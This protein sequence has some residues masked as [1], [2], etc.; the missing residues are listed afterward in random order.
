MV[1]RRLVVSIAVIAG[2]FATTAASAAMGGV[3][4]DVPEDH[5]FAH[6]IEWAKD[7]GLVVGYDNGDFGP[8]DSVTRGQLSAIM[9]RYHERLAPDNGQRLDGSKGDKGDAGSAG[10]N[11]ASGANGQHGTNGTNGEDGK[12]AYEIAVDNG[13]DGDVEDWLDS[14][15]GEDGDDG[16]DG[17]P[18]QN[19]QDGASAEDLLGQSI[20]SYLD[21]K[22]NGYTQALGPDALLEWDWSQTRSN[23]YHVF[24]P[25]G[26]FV[27]TTAAAGTNDKVAGYLDVEDYPLVGL[28]GPFSIDYNK[29]AGNFAF[30]PGL[31][32]VVDFDG[33]GTIDGIL[34]GEEVYGGTDW[35]LSNSAAQ[36]VKD[37]A[38]NNSGGFGSQWHGSIADWA[39]AFPD[40]EVVHIGFSLGSGVYS[41]GYITGMTLGGVVY[42][43]TA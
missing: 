6:A 39:L 21:E 14:L 36:F 31:Q 9:K 40:A 10:A 42:D 41:V 11:G 23:G 35:W 7:N 4:G 34:V 33:N 17:A 13:F 8:E 12:S 5:V 30:D 38:P 24:T 18:G 20:Q 25:Q 28:S 1:K 32:A 37:G 19:G 43:F 26:L 22:V 29:V 3:F 15:E 27:S 2:M 16:E